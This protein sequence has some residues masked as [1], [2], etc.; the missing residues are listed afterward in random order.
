MVSED[1]TRRPKQCRQINSWVKP[2]RKSRGGIFFI[3]C[4]HPNSYVY[5]PEFF[6]MLCRNGF[7]VTQMGYRRNPRSNKNSAPMSI[8]AL[9]VA[10]VTFVFGLCFVYLWRHLSK[11]QDQGT[12]Q[13]RSKQ[14]KTEA[15]IASSHWWRKWWYTS[16]QLETT[17]RERYNTCYREAGLI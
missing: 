16:N 2:F 17:I 15:E 10:F 11:T 7:T 3:L 12:T 14:T 4:L 8:S 1:D 9:V 6:L 13:P 5:T